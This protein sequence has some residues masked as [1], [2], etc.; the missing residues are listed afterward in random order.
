MLANFNLTSI[1][2]Q[3]DLQFKSFDVQ[4]YASTTGSDAGALLAGAS[5]NIGGAGYQWWDIPITYTLLAGSYYVL[6]FRP[7][8]DAVSDWLDNAGTGLTYC[9]DSALPV[10]VGAFRLDQW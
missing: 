7:T 10:D 5:G 4:V 1:G 3:A 2:I 9:N 8:I 6:H